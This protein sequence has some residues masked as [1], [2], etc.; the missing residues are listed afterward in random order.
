M[1]YGIEWA[2]RAD[3]IL[4]GLDPWF[5]SAVLD[6]A[7]RLAGAPTR[8]SRARGSPYY[9][10]DQRYTFDVGGRQVTLFFQ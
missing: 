7:D 8:L 5:A 1:S 10:R 4:M 2:P 3:A 6:G 9:G